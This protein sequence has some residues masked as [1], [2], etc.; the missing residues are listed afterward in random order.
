[1]GGNFFFEK[2]VPCE[3]IKYDFKKGISTV[4]TIDV[5]SYFI[6]FSNK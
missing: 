3:T 6:I 4:S 1:M 2:N 5:L